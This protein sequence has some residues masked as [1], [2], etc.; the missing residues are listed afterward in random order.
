MNHEGE[1]TEQH[2]Q[3]QFCFLYFFSYY[4]EY[5]ILNHLPA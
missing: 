4:N 5:I 3:H 2:A 1:K